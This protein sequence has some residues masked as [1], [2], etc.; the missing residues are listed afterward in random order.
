MALKIKNNKKNNDIKVTHDQIRSA[1][2]RLHLTFN[3]SFLTSNKEFNLENTEFDTA[4]R[5]QL[6]QRLIELSKEDLIFVK[7]GKKFNYLECLK[8][9]KLSKCRLK[10][11]SIHPTFENG[12]RIKIAGDNFW[13]FR[14][15]CNNMPL[16]SRVIGKMIDHTFYVMFIDL[17][18]ALYKG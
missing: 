17:K 1:G 8:K 15:Y 11:M 3:F 16:P 9:E 6:L 10:K 12:S 2:E 7:A 4:H 14:L 13:V 18:H 5:N